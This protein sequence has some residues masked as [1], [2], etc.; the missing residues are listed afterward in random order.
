MKI[1]EK[2]LKNLLKKLKKIYFKEKKAIILVL[3]TEEISL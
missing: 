1:S 2:S 3:Q